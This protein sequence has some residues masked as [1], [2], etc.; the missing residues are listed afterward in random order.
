MSAHTPRRRRLQPALVAP[1]LLL[2][3]TACGSTVAPNGQSLS[4]LPADTGQELGAPTGT[5]PAGSAL[6]DGSTSVPGAPLAGGA[7]AGSGAAGP[8]TVS[9]QPEA[10][11]A[12]AAQGGSAVSQGGAANAPGAPAAPTGPRNSSPITLGVLAAGDPQEGAKQ[13][14]SSSGTSASLKETLRAVLDHFKKQGGIAGRPIKEIFRDIPVTT[15]DYNTYLQSMCSLFTEDNDADVVLSG[16]GYYTESFTACL[17]RAGTPQIE[18][19]YGGT[20]ARDFARYRSYYTPNHS[21]YDTRFNAV[22]RAGVDAGALKRGMKVGVVIEDCPH[23][24]RAFK[25]SF[26]PAAKAAGLELD[27]LTHECVEGFKSA[28]GI[29]SANQSAV[30]RFRA[31]GVETVMFAT[32][33]TGVDLAFFTPAASSQGWKPRYWLDSL[34]LAATGQAS[35]TYAEDQVPQM[36]GAGWLEV[37]DISRPTYD[38]PVQK[39][40]LSIVQPRVQLQTT[41][42]Y[43]LAF[44]AC[45]AFFLLEAALLKTGGN[46]APDQLRAG[47]AAVGTSQVL[48]AISGRTS[49]SDSKR[50]GA[51]EWTPF[52]YKPGCRCFEYT[53]R[54][55][56]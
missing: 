28:G 52:A 43:Y 23:I 55:R 24:Q 38:S 32:Y 56:A 10:A 26:L 13:A 19:A 39:R 21:T 45:D 1:A 33:A 44:A 41:A 37:F 34:G 54:P 14:G 2:A 4:Q 48:S 7:P 30:T 11:G 15:S 6:G 3:L 27:T 49:L 46:A 18:G 17:D 51:V 29:A 22:I 20:D 35:G 53:G 31:N 5:G 12:A 8:E 25:G 16:I 36:A 9:V 42:D 50:A 47:V 40:C